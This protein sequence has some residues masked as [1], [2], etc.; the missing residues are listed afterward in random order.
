[1][2]TECLL[3]LNQWKQKSKHCQFKTCLM[4]LYIS[5]AIKSPLKCSSV[6][7]SC[8]LIWLLLRFQFIYRACWCSGRLV[9]RNYLVWILVRL[10]A[11][12]LGFHHFPQSLHMN[13]RIV[14]WNRLNHLIPNSYLFTIHEHLPIS[15]GA[16]S[17][18]QLKQF[19]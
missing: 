16:I 10:P 4:L 18:L 6:R 17:P 8:L 11:T 5:E 7:T 2:N 13:G 19:D 3:L 14:P 15:V 9:F 12:L 1:M